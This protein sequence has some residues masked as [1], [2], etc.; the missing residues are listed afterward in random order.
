MLFKV[1]LKSR[2][3]IEVVSYD[4]MLTIFVLEESD[5]WRPVNLPTFEAATMFPDPGCGLAFLLS[6][7]RP[8]T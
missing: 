5:K 3:P 7:S 2:K 1:L 4:I 6:A 8:N